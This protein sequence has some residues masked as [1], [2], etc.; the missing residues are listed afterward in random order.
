METTVYGSYIN[1]KSIHTVYSSLISFIFNI[2]ICV[3]TIP[4]FGVLGAALAGS[5]SSI[6]AFTFRTILGQREYSSVDNILKTVIAIMIIFACAF[7]NYFITDFITR[8]I[9]FFVLLIV[10]FIIYND[11][12]KYMFRYLREFLGKKV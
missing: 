6:A 1:K 11:K 10:T 4:H 7:L 2:V 3:I 5:I 12:V 9:T 8:S